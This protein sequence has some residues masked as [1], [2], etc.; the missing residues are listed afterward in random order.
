[1]MESGA[2]DSRTERLI[3]FVLAKG[4]LPQRLLSCRKLFTARQDTL[5]GEKTGYFRSRILCFADRASLYNL[6]NK[7][8]SMDDCP[9]C[10]LHTGQSF[11]QN[12]KYQVSHKYSCIS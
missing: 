7:A 5:N 10:T 8:S 1:V 6:V 2:S 3:S 12:N 4:T 11:L 9:V